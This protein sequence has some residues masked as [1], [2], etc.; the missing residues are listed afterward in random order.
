MLCITLVKEPEMVGEVAI[1]NW[2]R[3]KAREGH[4]R[5][6]GERVVF[7]VVLPARLFFGG[8]TLMV[9]IAQ[10]IVLPLPDVP[11]W[12]KVAFMPIIPLAL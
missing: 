1:V 8:A 3:R 10:A 11:V 2:F 5:E 7:P 6:D 12:E 4:A 9:L